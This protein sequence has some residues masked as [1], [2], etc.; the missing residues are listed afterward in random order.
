MASLLDDIGQEA[1]PQTERAE[2]LMKGNQP[3]DRHKRVTQRHGSAVG[4][5]EHPSRHHCHNARGYLDMENLTVCPTLAVVP[6]Q[7]A[8]IQ[9]MPPIVDDD[10]ILDMGRMT[11]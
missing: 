8:P 4:G 5:V 6:P 11:P 7:R 3:R 1:S 10:F 2:H 9:R